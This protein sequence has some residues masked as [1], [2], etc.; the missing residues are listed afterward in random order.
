MT[1]N[2][3]PGKREEPKRLGIIPYTF[4]LPFLSDENFKPDYPKN[5]SSSQV[6]HSRF[7]DEYAAVENG[8]SSLRPS[9][10]SRTAFRRAFIRASAPSPEGS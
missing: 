8:G 3:L 9:R 2:G 1:A 4:I 10:Q 6:H 5:R 7:A